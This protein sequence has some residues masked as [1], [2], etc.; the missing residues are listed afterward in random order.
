MYPHRGRRIA[1]AVGE[2]SLAARHSGDDAG[3]LAIGQAYPRT[4]EWPQKRPP[5]VAEAVSR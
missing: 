4:T 1:G 3:I 5:L 2:R